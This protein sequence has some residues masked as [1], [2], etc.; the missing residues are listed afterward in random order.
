MIDT[1]IKLHLAYWALSGLAWWGE[2]FTSP[3]YL[4]KKGTAN[5]DK[6]LADIRLADRFS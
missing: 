1:T 3:L 5:L 2:E 6:L 4:H